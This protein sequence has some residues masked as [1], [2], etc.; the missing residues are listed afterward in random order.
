MFR[1]LRGFRAEMVTTGTRGAPVESP[2]ETTAVGRGE[3]NADSLPS[4]RTGESRGRFEALITE[5][6]DGLYRTALRLTKERTRAEDLTQDVMLKAWRS[7]HTFQ[8]GSSARAWLHRILMNAYYD[9][10]RKRTREPEVVDLEDVGEFYLYDKVASRGDLAEAG[11]PEVLLDQIMDD[12]V[13]RSLDDLPEAFRAAVI[14]A[15]LEGFSY[16]EMAEIMG[17]PQGTVMSRLSRGRHLLQKNL[18]QYAR[19][20]HYIKGDAR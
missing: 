18:W 13:R 6:L 9:A 2:A 7:F 19:D 17:V 14:L 10:Y 15:D 20:R 3:T 1:V 12:E 8:E 5:H 16:K 11:N 4:V